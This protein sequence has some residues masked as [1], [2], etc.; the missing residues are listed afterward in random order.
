MLN[1]TYEPILAESYSAIRLAHQSAVGNILGYARF[2]WD[3]VSS[4]ELDGVVVGAGT[5]PGGNS[6]PFNEGDTLV[7]EVGHW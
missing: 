2:P 1:L 3:Y 7:H 6:A 5:A 4:P